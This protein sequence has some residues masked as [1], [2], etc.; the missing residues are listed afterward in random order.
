VNDVW[1]ELKQLKGLVDGKRN[2]ETE[3]RRDRRERGRETGEKKE[4]RKK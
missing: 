2:R 1:A 3:K 4:R